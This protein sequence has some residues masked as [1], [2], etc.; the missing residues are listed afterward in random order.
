[1]TRDLQDS[2]LY[3]ECYRRKERR[4]NFRFF[5]V[6]V[7]I[8]LA[9]AGLRF[10]WVNHFGGV[11]VDG[12][13][14]RKTLT[15]GEQLVMQYTSSERPARRG[16]IIVVEVKGYEEFA[17]DGVEF[18]IKRLIAIE[19]DTVRCTDGQIEIRYAG[20]DT[21]VPLDEPYA[22]YTDREKYDFGGYEYTVGEGQVFFLGDNRNNSQDSRYLE[23]RGSRLKDLY[24]ESDIIGFI[25]DWALKY[26][27]ILEVIF[28]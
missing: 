3:E 26:Q 7:C 21:F 5:A 25:P 6:I 4:S 9:F 15:S 23:E 24:K 28:F 14:M 10:Y 18:L 8:A 22:Y 2:V 11:Q 27:K 12:G 16:E 20:T 19:G 13:S 17:G 1:M